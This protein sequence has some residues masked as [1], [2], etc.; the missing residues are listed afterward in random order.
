MSLRLEITFAGD[1]AGSASD[2]TRGRLVATLNGRT[3][4][5]LDW[6]WIELVEHLAA[7]WRFLLHEESAPGPFNPYEPDVLAHEARR[8]FEEN[9]SEEEENA[10]EAFIES[11]DLSRALKGAWPRRL[12]LIRCGHRMLAWSSIAEALLPLNDVLGELQSIADQICTRLEGAQDDRSQRARDAWADRAS[13]AEMERVALA[14]GLP[15]ESLAIAAGETDALEFWAPTERSQELVAVARM[16]AWSFDASTLRSVLAA[17]RA[18]AR[19]STTALDAVA[20]QAALAAAPPD[21]AHLEGYR[22]AG[23]V[24][25][26]LK[27]EG[28]FDIAGVL[29]RW[30]VACRQIPMPSAIDAIC[31]WGPAH[32]PVILANPRGLH[33]ATARGLRTTLAHELCHLVLD[34]EGALPVAEVLGGSLPPRVERRAR[35]FAAELLLPRDAARVAT[36][37][38]LNSGGDIEDVVAALVEEYDVSREVA[39]W[40]IRNSGADLTTLDRRFLQQLVSDPTRF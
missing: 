36:E 12:W 11:H 6:T 2:R 23:F 4:W 27:I 30:N 26:R 22:A 1:P 28:R 29:A 3:L 13:I 17:I 21:A 20:D 24:R 16:T 5:D 38:A 32:G 8:Y 37:A 14:T 19:H 7:N 10:F 31:A 35:A 9:P 25:G 15:I 18:E 40:Q 33:A 39:A 34:R